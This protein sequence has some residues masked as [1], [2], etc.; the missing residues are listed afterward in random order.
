VHAT[1]GT[2]RDVDNPLAL[3]GRH[4]DAHPEFPLI[5]S[6]I[7]ATRH[8]DLAYDILD[9]AFLTRWDELVAD[10]NEPE[11]LPPLRPRVPIADQTLERR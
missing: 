11:E 8:A 9:T 6:L 2:L 5:T 4:A 10:G 7:H 3:F 1:L